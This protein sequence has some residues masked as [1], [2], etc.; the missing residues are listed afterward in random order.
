MIKDQA[1][2]SHQRIKQLPKRGFETP[3]GFFSFFGQAQPT[4]RG[5]EEP[6]D[7][8][9]SYHQPLPPSQRGVGNLTG[10]QNVHFFDH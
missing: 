6:I 8:V 7:F 10:F 2:S 4:Q 5:V 1:S 9:R 3:V